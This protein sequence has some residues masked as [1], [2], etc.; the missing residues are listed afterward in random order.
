MMKTVVIASAARTPIGDFGAALRDVKPVDLMTAVMK[1]CL[2][3]V[4]R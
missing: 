3:L 1:E 4:E 2:I